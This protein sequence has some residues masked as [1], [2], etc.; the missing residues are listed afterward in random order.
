M[1]FYFYGG[2]FVENK[3]KIITVVLCVAAFFLGWY[4]RALLHIALL[5]SLEIQTEVKYKRYQKQ[6][7]LCA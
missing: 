7:L 1:P 2:M 3:Y 5:Q 6:K 4:A